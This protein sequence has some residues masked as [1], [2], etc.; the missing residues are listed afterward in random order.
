MRKFCHAKEFRQLHIN[1]TYKS[2]KTSVKLS[3][4]WITGNSLL[5]IFQLRMQVCYF[6][7][8]TKSRDVR[9]SAP[10]ASSALCI[11]ELSHVTLG[12]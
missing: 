5:C 7:Q 10:K 1:E 9:L 2:V 4:L 6:H 11:E 3:E 12:R 8:R